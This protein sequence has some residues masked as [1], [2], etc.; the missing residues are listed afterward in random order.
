M[1][2]ADLRRVRFG[3]TGG[4]NAIEVDEVVLRV[5]DAI[6][7]G[8]SPRTLIENCDLGIARRGYPVPDVDLLLDEVLA[9]AS[10]SPYWTRR[11]E[12]WREFDV[13]N[14][15]HSS[16]NTTDIEA[17]QPVVQQRRT[18]HLRPSAK[19][20]S[21]DLDRLEGTHLRYVFRTG[22]PNRLVEG[23]RL[24]ATVRLSRI[25]LCVSGRTYTRRRIGRE[26]ASEPLIARHANL[27]RDASRGRYADASASTSPS[28][29]ILRFIHW[30]WGDGSGD[31]IRELR[32][33]SLGSPVLWSSG[34]HFNYTMTTLISLPDG[35]WFR[36]PVR[37]RTRKDAVMTAVDESLN[38]VVRY[39]KAR[40]FS[41][42]ISV[43]VNPVFTLTDDLILVI[44]L[45]APLVSRYFNTPTTVTF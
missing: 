11:V 7:A 34:N 28:S 42:E 22:L 44:A 40:R 15:M 27:S 3:R 45:T 9:D 5:A 16:E 31:Q 23:D 14:R 2:S 4:Y 18:E 21:E 25:T 43:V 29:P 38:R 12:R 33:D 39:K 20:E 41:S 36:F 26:R 35:R 1:R 19:S 17:D 10:D 32:D 24:L 13:G 30:Y 6:D 8:E 37:G